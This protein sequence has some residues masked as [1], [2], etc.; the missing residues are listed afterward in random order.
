MATL[1]RIPYKYDY[2]SDSV[3]WEG[4][5]KYLL[6]DDLS[7]YASDAY[8]NLATAFL[9][10]DFSQIPSN[11]I[12][13]KVT[14]TI[15]FETQGVISFLL[16]KDA[17]SSSNYT[18]MQKSS[19]VVY[20]NNN[21]SGRGT[22]SF[23]APQEVITNLN[24]D[25]GILRDNRF[26]LRLYNNRKFYGRIYD[27]RITI[28]Y[29]SSYTISTSV[30]PAGCGTVSGAGTYAEGTDI[31]LTATPANGYRFVKW[32]KNGSDDNN[33]SATRTITVS[34]DA[35]Y[36]AIFALNSYSVSRTLSHATM[37]NSC[38]TVSHGSSYQ[39]T[40]YADTD[41]E[42]STVTVMMGGVDITSSV[43]ANGQVTIASVTGNISIT[44]EA[45][46]VRLPEITSFTIA[47]N[48][49]TSGQGVVL[50][51]VFT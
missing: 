10:Y 28:T 44:V 49:V 23:N 5:L 7:T 37:S 4:E 47:P 8:Y 45:T 16:C 1:T 29:S 46:Y 17:I 18:S 12:I 33:T 13:I 39:S 22:L 34:E 24:D 15:K 48:P 26:S 11:A 25:I 3:Y 6:D 9:F 50:T 41:Y 27:V 38:T 20:N 36:T 14:T 32:Q 51:V 31:T 19:T 21:K 35:V 30:L 2:I 40:V 42:I 43:Y